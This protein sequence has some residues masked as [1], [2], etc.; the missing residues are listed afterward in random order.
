MLFVGKRPSRDANTT[1]H[2]YWGRESATFDNV[3]PRIGMGDGGYLFD[4]QNDL[5]A[6]MIYP[7]RHAC[8][9]PLRGKVSI[10]ARP[11][12]PE[13]VDVRNSSATS[14]DL[15]GYTVASYPYVYS[16]G[17]N[18]VLAP[19]ETLRLH[20]VGPRRADTALDRY[21]GKKSSILNNA[22]DY[23]RLRTATNISIDCDA[24]GSVR[25]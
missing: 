19:G 6:R 2:F 13:E 22:G 21:W 20:V 4:P 1:T 12:S 16:F 10:S 14:V 11:S 23:V 25:C 3:A 24:W 15:E 17:A 18:T 7:C 5:R 9:D 8:A